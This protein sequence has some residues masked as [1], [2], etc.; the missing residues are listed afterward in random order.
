[1]D[2]NS[3]GVIFLCME[4]GTGK[5]A[6][7]NRIDGLL[8]NPNKSLIK[9]AVIRTYSIS[10]AQMRGVNDFIGSMNSV[11]AWNYDHSNDLRASQGELPIIGISDPDP[12]QAIADLLNVY[13]EIYDEMF[14]I[15]RL[16]LVIDGID[17]ITGK[18]DRI[19]KYL[20]TV[21]L[22]DDGV[23]IICT[24][25]FEDEADVPDYA[26]KYITI[27]RNASDCRIEIRRNTDEYYDVLSR[28]VTKTDKKI[29]PEKV[30]SII[31]KADYR[32]LYLKVFMPFM[33]KV[34]ESDYTAHSV[35]EWYLGRIREKYDKGNFW[36]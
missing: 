12:K 18:T 35:I 1:M 33:D 29:K 13:H 22:L 23:Y 4:R 2:N 34:F 15:E 3:R 20:P 24:S 31:Q 5:S 30:R 19:L 25:R 9:N 16:I 11:F 10:N 8:N 7:A 28:Y 27:V 26:E 21:D 32:I 14:C 36:G 17:E 6:F